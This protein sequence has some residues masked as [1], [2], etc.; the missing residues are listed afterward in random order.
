MCCGEPQQLLTVSIWLNIRLS[1]PLL[2]HRTKESFP[3]GDEARG[4]KLVPDETGSAE[5]RQRKGCFRQGKGRMDLSLVTR[6]HRVYC[7][8]HQNEKLVFLSLTYSLHGDHF[9]KSYIQ[10]W[11]PS[12]SP[13]RP[14]L[15]FFF[16]LPHIITSVFGLRLPPGPSL[17]ELHLPAPQP[18][19][20]LQKSNLPFS[21]LQL[22]IPPLPVFW[23]SSAANDGHSCWGKT[24]LGEKIIVKER[25]SDRNNL[26]KSYYRAIN[27]NTGFWGRVNEG[28][29]WGQPPTEDFDW[30][31]MFKNCSVMVHQSWTVYS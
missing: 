2:V 8:W 22:C 30:L 1:V 25:K 21:S 11:L 29:G 18:F 23:P 31:V 13:S 27:C 3:P 14:P 19:D 24:T 12:I 16:I 17:K 15:F 26:I 10:F 20:T 7:L 28:W 6:T 5:W 4:G 9:F